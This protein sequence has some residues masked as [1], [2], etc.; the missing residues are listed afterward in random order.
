MPQFDIGLLFNF[1][2]FFSVAYIFLYVFNIRFPFKNTTAVLKL[3]VKIVA[4]FSKLFF[5]LNK[6]RFSILKIIVDWF[7][8]FR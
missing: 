1:V 6:K 7:N 8:S 5:N 2:F 4:F 3:K